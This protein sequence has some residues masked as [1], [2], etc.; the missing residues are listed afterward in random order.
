MRG[1]A[2][3]GWALHLTTQNRNLVTQDENLE[4]G[5]LSDAIIRGEDGEQA[6]ENRIEKR[7]EHE[8]DSATLDRRVLPRPEC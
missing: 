3:V 2:S 4:L 7:G 6:T 8:R 1:L 5:L